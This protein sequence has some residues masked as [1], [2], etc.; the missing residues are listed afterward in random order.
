MEQKLITAQEA[1]EKAKAF[2]DMECICEQI[3]RAAE[4]G[5]F[6]TY[7]GAITPQDK[8]I[9][10]ALGYIVKEIDD[11]KFPVVVSWE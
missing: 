9:L 3:E 7:L 6:R 1:N 4:K 10:E 2:S 5:Y 11:F 8:V